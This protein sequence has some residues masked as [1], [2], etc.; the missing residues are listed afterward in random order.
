MDEN[1]CNFVRVPMKDTDGCNNQ[2]FT[3]NELRHKVYGPVFTV[4][5][6]LYGSRLPRTDRSIMEQVPEPHLGFRGTISAS[7]L[8]SCEVG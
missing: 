7:G 4:S 3:N 5:K 6:A 8:G 1:W 2:A